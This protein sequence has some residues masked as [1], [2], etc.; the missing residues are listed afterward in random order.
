MQIDGRWNVRYAI[1]YV[2]PF[3]NEEGDPDESGEIILSSGQIIGSD[4]WGGSYNGT[5]DI[6]G[7]KISSSVT[8]TGDESDPEWEPIFEGIKSPFKLILNGEFNSPDYFSM[9]GN[10]DDAPQHQVVLNCSRIK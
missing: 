3:S 1:N 10:V 5:Y 9:R 4:P 8:V 6:K 7:N 2:N